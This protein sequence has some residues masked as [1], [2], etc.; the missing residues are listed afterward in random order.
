MRPWVFSVI[1]PHSGRLSFTSFLFLIEPDQFAKIVAHRIKFP[2]VYPPV[3]ELLHRFRDWNSNYFSHRAHLF[4]QYCI[5]TYYD[6]LQP[7]LCFGDNKTIACNK[8]KA[9]LGRISECSTVPTVPR[10]HSVHRVLRVPR[11]FA[12]SVVCNA[13][14]ITTSVPEVARV[15]KSIIYAT[16]NGYCASVNRTRITF[17]CLANFASWRQTRRAFR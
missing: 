2:G 13:F 12:V 4:G 8:L 7:L 9:L 6:L 10:V 15:V 11:P 5:T 1:A 14:F 17:G 3:Y 16:H